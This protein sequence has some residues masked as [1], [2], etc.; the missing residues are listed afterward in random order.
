MKHLMSIREARNLARMLSKELHG[1]CRCEFEGLWRMELTA[2]DRKSYLEMYDATTQQTYEFKSIPSRND[3]PCVPTN[4]RTK[5]RGA[6][7]DEW[8]AIPED[9]VEY[10]ITKYEIL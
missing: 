4:W 6:S 5:P 9:F 2:T 10:T 8:Q 1:V 7:R 3:Q